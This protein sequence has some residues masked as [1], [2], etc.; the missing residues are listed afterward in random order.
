L[1][2]SFQKE[3]LEQENV[4]DRLVESAYRDL[5]RIHRFLGDTASVIAAVRRDP[6]PVRRILDIGCAQGGVLRDVRKQLGVEVVGVDL[7]L[8][9]MR[10]LPFSIVRADA[11]RDPLPPAD[12]AF[13]MHLGHHLSEHDLAALIRNVGRCCRRFIL[14]DLVR[15][16]LPLVL[17]SPICCTPGFADCRG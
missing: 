3:I 15:H 11:V 12:L 6:L 13:S 10:D 17:F 1:Q 8:P 14:L 16:P 5:T 9:V 4:P 2:R 7:N